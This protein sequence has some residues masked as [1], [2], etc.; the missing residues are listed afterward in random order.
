MPI[1]ESSARPS[2]F[3]RASS[4][5]LFPNNPNTHTH[6]HTHTHTFKR[7]SSVC[8]YVWVPGCLGSSRGSTAWCCRVWCPPRSRIRWQSSP[9]RCN[10]TLLVHAQSQLNTY[11]HTLGIRYIASPPDLLGWGEEGKVARWRRFWTPDAQYNDSSHV[12]VIIAIVAVVVIV[13]AIVVVVIEVVVVV[14]V[15]VVVRRITSLA[16]ARSIALNSGR[17]AISC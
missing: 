15:V 8:M 2:L 3:S 9:R 4:S 6:T 17:F 1:K 11:I 14:V 13:V 5:T 10:C 16:H 12:S 7:S